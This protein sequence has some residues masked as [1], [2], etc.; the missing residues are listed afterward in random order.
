M[1]MVVCGQ[2]KVWQG[3]I[4]YIESPGCLTY[5]CYSRLG[6]VWGSRDI[7]VSYRNL[8][9][10]RLETVSQRLP[11]CWALSIESRPAATRLDYGFRL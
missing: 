3:L 2:R 6:A 1:G 11:Q 8:L 9:R 4:W 7:Q 10:H 5:M